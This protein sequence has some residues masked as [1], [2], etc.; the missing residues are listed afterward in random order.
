MSLLFIVIELVALN[1][2]ASSTSYT[3]AKMLTASNHLVGGFHRVLSD[4]GD[5][6]GLRKENDMLLEELAAL[7]NELEELKSVFPGDIEDFE[8]SHG[9]EYSYITASVINNSVTRQENFITVD[10]G[11]RDGVRI[12]MALVTP[13][14]KIVGYV[15]DCSENFSIAISVLNR[16]FRTG[17]RIKGKEYF[18]SLYWD[19]V[20]PDYITLSEIPKYADIEPGDT[21]VTGYSSIFPPDIEVGT[22]VETEMTRSNYYTAKLR[23]STPMARLGRLFVVNYVDIHERMLLEEGLF[24]ER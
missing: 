2:Y 24:D 20:S 17:G 12:N 16:E 14:R 18:G 11:E 5:Y 13:D 19:G 6:F 8:N 9:G 23:L 3:K 4:V 21:I 1:Y 7:R 22:V 15:L 10:K